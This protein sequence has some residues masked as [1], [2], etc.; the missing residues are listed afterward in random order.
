MEDLEKSQIINLEKFKAKTK[1]LKTS[2]HKELEDA[3]LDAAGTTLQYITIYALLYIHYS[4]YKNA[5]VLF[6]DWMC[7]WYIYEY[8]GL[9]RL[10]QIKN[11]ELQHMKTLAATI[12]AQRS[13]LEKFLLDSLSEVL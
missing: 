8:V 10:V 7:M 6:I 1:E 13:D 4:Y 9:R 12:I 2:I 5:H 3:T 11:K